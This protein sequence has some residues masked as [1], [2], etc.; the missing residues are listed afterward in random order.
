MIGTITPMACWSEFW[1]I[2]TPIIANGVHETP[3]SAVS[4]YWPECY[5]RY[6]RRSSLGYYQWLAIDMFE[7]IENLVWCR[8]SWC[9][10]WAFSES[11][12]QIRISEL[13]NPT[14]WSFGK[15]WG[16]NWTK[17]YKVVNWS[18]WSLKLEAIEV[19]R[20]SRTLSISE[21]EN[22]CSEPSAW[23]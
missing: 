10:G 19:A 11:E 8:D 3:L 1:H 18:L 16:D 15:L 7:S 12:I 6:D 5:G 22:M 14:W 4:M 23:S 13:R 17:F 2:W 20:L 9:A 21:S